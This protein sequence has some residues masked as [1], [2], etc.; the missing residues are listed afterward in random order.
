MRIDAKGREC[1]C[2]RRGC[3]DV[4]AS[5]RTLPPPSRRRGLAWRRD[6]EVRVRALGVGIANLLKVFHTPLVILDGI[7]N[8]YGDS[9][10]P[11]LAAALTSELGGL[12]LPTPELAF[13]EDAEFKASTGAALRAGD[14]FLVDHLLTT[15]LALGK[16]S[17]ASRKRSTSAD[18]G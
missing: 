18:R 14:A 3:L 7:Y 5:G 4:V 16:T 8:E 13:G 2:G 12:G 15:E 6:L 11:T 17:P 10:R 9:V 1:V